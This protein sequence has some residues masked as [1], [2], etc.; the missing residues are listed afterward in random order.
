MLI[1]GGDINIDTESL[2]F[3]NKIEAYENLPCEHGLYKC[4]YNVTR[5]A[6]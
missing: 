1:N 5:A 6:F 4:F 2:L 3:D